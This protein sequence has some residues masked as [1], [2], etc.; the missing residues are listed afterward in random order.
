MAALLTHCPSCRAARLSY[1]LLLALL[2]GQKQALLAQ[3]PTAKPLNLERVLRAGR[4]RQRLLLLLATTANQ[5]DFKRQK[6]LLADA[7]AGLA[8]RDFRVVEV[9]YDQLGPSDRPLLLR[10]LGGP[11]PAFAAVLIGKDGGVKLRQ[12]RPVTPQELFGLVDQMPMRR[13]EMRRP[14]QRP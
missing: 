6:S 7:L 10:K 14:P 3:A 5:P 1:W 9:L 13:Q 11:L 2:M 4:G 8:E 12:T